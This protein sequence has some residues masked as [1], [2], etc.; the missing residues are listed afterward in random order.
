ME[1]ENEL[2]NRLIS[3]VNGVKVRYNIV[4]TKD[5]IMALGYSSK[6][7]FSDLAAG[8][9]EITDRFLNAMADKFKINPA[10][11]RTGEGSMWLDDYSNGYNYQSGSHLYSNVKNDTEL[12]CKVMD[13]FS[14]S[15]KRQD[16]I[17]QRL[18]E[19][20][21]RH[22][23]TMETLMKEVANYRNMIEIVNSQNQRLMTILEKMNGIGDSEK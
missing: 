14:N 3:V 19:M 15:R 13:E 9:F 23:S 16:E 5:I 12:M 1:E 7:Y 17:N 2:K 21:D 18:L 8:K 11:I 10:Y 6:S 4:T 22:L 20:A